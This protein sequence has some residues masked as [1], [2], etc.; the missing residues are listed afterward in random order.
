LILGLG[1]PK[2]KTTFLL[3]LYFGRKGMHPN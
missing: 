2:L 3:F 1:H